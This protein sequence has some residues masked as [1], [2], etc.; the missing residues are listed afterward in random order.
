MHNICC[1]SVIFYITY[2]STSFE[3]KICKTPNVV[4]VI[5][6]SIQS[7]AQ[8]VMMTSMSCSCAQGA[9][10]MKHVGSFTGTRSKPLPRTI[11]LLG[12]RTLNWKGL[13]DVHTGKHTATESFVTGH[14]QKPTICAPKRHAVI[15]LVFTARHYASMVYAIVSV[16]PSVR[17]SVT[18]RYF[19]KT[20]K[21]RIT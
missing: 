21:R 18:C 4:T 19:T 9:I 14:H 6:N 17:P 20:A 12:S 3:S 8:P 16:C 10:I 13:P 11:T 15:A 2:I 7:L 1:L 5:T